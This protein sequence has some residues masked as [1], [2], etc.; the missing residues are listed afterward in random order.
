M[1][2]SENLDLYLKLEKIDCIRFQ[3]GFL[4]LPTGL[5]LPNTNSNTR[6]LTCRT[7]QKKN[8]WKSKNF[9]LQLPSED[10]FQLRIL[11]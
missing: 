5:L 6:W 9:Q 7:L 4:Q 1:F 11:K 8:F 3:I 2:F 10:N